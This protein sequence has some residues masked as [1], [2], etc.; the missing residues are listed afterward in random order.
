MRKQ[1]SAKVL[2][3]LAVS[4]TFGLIIKALGFG[5]G[6]GVVRTDGAFVGVMVTTDP[7]ARAE[8]PEGRWRF[9]FCREGWEGGRWTRQ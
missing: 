1:P 5:K 3:V 8:L 4:Q 9:P 7:A 2:A 6:G